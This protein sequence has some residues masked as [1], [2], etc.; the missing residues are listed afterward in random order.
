MTMKSS[1]VEFAEAFPRQG[2][3]TC[4]VCSSPYREEMESAKRSAG[5]SYANME[6]WLR[7]QHPQH[8]IKANT[9]ARHFTGGHVG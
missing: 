2:G 8:V 9:I 4:T 5:V 3:V 6:R 7:A 1:L